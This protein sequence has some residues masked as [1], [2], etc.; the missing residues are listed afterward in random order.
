[1]GGPRSRSLA[2]ALAGAVWLAACG[3]PETRP[4]IVVVTL[5]TTRAD[6]LSCLGGP[7][8]NTPRLD[9]L[10]AR[11]ALFSRAYADSN[12]TNPSHVS[13]MTGLPAIDHGVMNQLTRIPPA[14]DT[15]AEVFQRA[16][17]RTGGFVSSRHVGPE[18]GWEGYDELPGLGNERSAAETTD[19][20]LAWL[21]GLGRRPFFLW[22]HYWDPHMQYQP[23]PELAARFYAGDR[24]A[25]SGPLLAEQPY[26]RLVQRDGVLDWLGDTRD[27]AWAPAMYAA[28]IHHTD[29]ELGRLLDAVSA[30]PGA[31]RTLI[32]VTADHGESLGEHGIYYAHT[33]LYEQQLAVPLI[34]HA[35]GAPPVQSD[36]LVSSLDIAPTVAELAGVELGRGGLP[37]ISLARV[38]RGQ[39]E[40]KLEAPRALIHQ[41]AHNLAVA[42]RDGGWK[43]IWPLG[44]DHPLLSGAP[45]LY[46]LTRDPGETDDR[47]AR[48][49][50]RVAALRRQLERWIARGPIE[51][52]NLPHLDAEAVERLRALGYLQD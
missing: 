39:P 6:Q 27:P 34:I 33:G 1:M 21:S 49:P 51:R 2:A 23:P 16:G 31:D 25:G 9:A 13:I 42:V 10:A 11:S 3:A 45:E 28:E 50:E 41:N 29:A 7:P 32:V 18:L 22:V 15:L 30:A 52:G 48:E 38:V 12:V 40:P 8:G 20:A 46:D 37:G 17:Y 26:F 4:N 36:A 35:P 44:K 47:A 43:L 19:L 24:A 14:I 5:D